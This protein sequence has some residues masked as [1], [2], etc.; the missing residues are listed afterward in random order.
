[1]HKYWIYVLYIYIC[2]Q[3]DEDFIAQYQINYGAT[4]EGAG[5]ELT[6][7]QKKAQQEEYWRNYYSVYSQAQPK[8]PKFDEEGNPI[9]DEDDDDNDDDKEGNK[10]EKKDSSSSKS[11]SKSSDSGND[12]DSSNAQQQT[13]NDPTSEEHYQYN[14]YYYGKEYADS[15]R[16]YYREHPDSAPMPDWINQNAEGEDRRKEKE[17]EKKKKKPDKGEKRKEPPREEG[18]IYHFIRYFPWICFWFVL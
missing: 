17:Q 6:E 8:L 1:M 2:F 15:Y 18:M 14:L 12:G 13:A 4:H 5:S 10:K 7:E 16:E 3:I 9:D 11:K